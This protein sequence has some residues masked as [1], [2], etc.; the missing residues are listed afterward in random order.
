MQDGSAISRSRS[1]IGDV[2]V[3]QGNLGEALKAYQE[4]LSAWPR[5]TL[6]MPASS[7]IFQLATGG[8]QRF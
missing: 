4:G 8:W 6:A 7:A 2:L 1:K 5:L 3:A